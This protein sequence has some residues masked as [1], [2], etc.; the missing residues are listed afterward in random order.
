MRNCAPKSNQPQLSPKQELPSLMRRGRPAGVDKRHLITS[1][2]LVAVFAVST[3]LGLA[4]YEVAEGAS[5]V[6]GR[7]AFSGDPPVA[8][9]GGSPEEEAPQPVEP[10]AAEP[11]PPA[12]PT[13]ITEGELARGDTLASVMH[14]SNV[15]REVI[16]FVTTELS[17]VFDFR[18]AQPGQR[19]RLVQDLQGQVQDFRYRTTPMES[20]HLAL[21]DGEYVVRREQAT[22]TPR[23][24]RIA[25]V[26]T[27]SLYGAMRDLGEGPQLANDFADVFAWD[28]DFSHG[29]QPGD[30]FRALYERLY[31]TDDDGTEVYAGP[32]RILAARYGSEAGEHTAVYFEFDEGRGGY[33]RPD[34]S[35]VERQF[36]LAPLRYSRISSRFSSARLHP[37]LKITRPHHGI[38]FA[39]KAGS[40]VWAVADGEVIYR[41]WAGGFGN[42]IKIRHVKDYVSYYAHLSRF[43]AGLHVGDRVQQKQVIGYVGQTGLATGPHVCF[44]ITQNGRYVNPASLR[45]PAA[46]PVPEAVRDDFVA[47]R[48]TLLSELDAGPLVASGEAL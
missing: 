37:I 9:E 43:A 11:E 47:T 46:K 8:L 15:P 24:S 21:E 22:L 20:I 2:A 35:S 36:L 30:E 40:P 16:H 38:D 31:Y 3:L 19:F 41:G 1:V 4:V 13:V 45:S 10:V 44:R 18:R 33:F 7:E 12:P 5:A 25:G 23:V 14:R 39:A 48:N 32:G 17:Q 42:L 6:V 28:V 27:S 26:V 34:G 29:V